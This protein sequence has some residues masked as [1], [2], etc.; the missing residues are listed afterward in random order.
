MRYVN[1]S[2]VLV[3][4]LVSQKVEARFPTYESLIN[5]KLM[6]P[7]EVSVLNSLVFKKHW[8][9]SKVAYLSPFLPT[10]FKAYSHHNV[11][12]TYFA[13]LSWEHCKR[14]KEWRNTK[15][16]PLTNSHGLQY[17]GQWNYCKKQNKKE[18]FR[19]VHSVLPTVAILEKKMYINLRII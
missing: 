10:Y 12:Y 15:R 19:W 2:N 4:R 7:S 11:L 1:L 14:L 3:Y 17:Y 18:K 16:L 6:L 5:A 9:N 13:I 8:K